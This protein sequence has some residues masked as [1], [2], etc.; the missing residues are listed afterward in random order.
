MVLT[1]VNTPNR[2]WEK[3]YP[4]EVTALWDLRP[5]VLVVLAYDTGIYAQLEN[6]RIVH[7]YLAENPHTIV[8]LRMYAELIPTF[9]PIAWADECYH[10]Y[11]WWGIKNAEVIP[12]NEFNI[13][14]GNENWSAHIDWLTA[15]ARHW[16]NLTTSIP[17]HL[18]AL[19]PVGEYR[20]GL[21]AYERAGLHK[22]YDRVDVHCYPG[23]FADWQFIYQTF[24][25]PVS[26]TEY[27]GIDPADYLI[28]LDPTCVRD[29]SWFILSG[30]D[31]QA[32]YHLIGSPYYDSLNATKRPVRQIHAGY[33]SLGWG[34]TVDNAQKSEKRRYADWSL[35]RISNGEDPLDR[36]AFADYIRAT[37]GDASDLRRYGMPDQ[38]TAARELKEALERAKVA[39]AQ[40]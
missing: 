32:A 1:G 25:V 27:N 8:I 19:S 30:T 5:E 7:Q 23:T 11:L 2:Q 16:R 38:A 21:R 40:I 13:E 35:E 4:E 6:R 14:G 22:L 12:A 34:A 9:H 31:D 24:A 15:F 18:P 3:W 36:S 17:L 26:I 37:G 39:L 28:R 33:Q 10:R 20:T 29:A